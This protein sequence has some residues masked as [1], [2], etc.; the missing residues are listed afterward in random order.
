[1]NDRLLTLYQEDLRVH[2]MGN[3]PGTKAY[4]E[5]RAQDSERRKTVHDL[6]AAGLLDSAE[7]FFHAAHIFNHGDLPEE[8]WEAHE[9]AVQAAQAGY[10]PARWLAAAAYDRSLVY[11]GKPQKYGTNYFSDGKHQHLLDVDPATTDEE[12]A[13]WDVP[14]LAEQLRKAEEATRL[15]PPLPVPPDPPAWLVEA[16]RRKRIEENDWTVDLDDKDHPISTNPKS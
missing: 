15:Y 1:M 11:Q 10:R 5:M 12:R 14:P 2:A 3:Q 7:D 8:A 16:I 13:E 4:K 6:I 9:L